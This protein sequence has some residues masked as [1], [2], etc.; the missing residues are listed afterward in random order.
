MIEGMKAYAVL[1][2]GKVKYLRLTEAIAKACAE[3]ERS[4]YGHDNVEVVPVV[5]SERK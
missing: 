3:I 4:V 2:D 5:L 1:N